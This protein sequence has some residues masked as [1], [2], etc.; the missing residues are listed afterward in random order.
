MLPKY[1]KGLSSQQLLTLC[2]AM[3]LKINTGS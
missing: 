2:F 1:F 3:T